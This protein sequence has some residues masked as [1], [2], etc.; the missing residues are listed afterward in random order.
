MHNQSIERDGVPP[1]LIS[2]VNCIKKMKI[3]NSIILILSVT[4][5]SA[6]YTINPDGT[7]NIPQKSLGDI[8]DEWVGFSEFYVYS[9]D[10]KIRDNG[11]GIM[12]IKLLGETEKK[13]VKVSI[14]NNIVKIQPKNP[15]DTWLITGEL[16]PTLMVI[17][18]KADQ[19]KH[20]PKLQLIRKTELLKRVNCKQNS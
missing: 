11:T 17:S 16:E 2:T 1:P 6:C 15:E 8:A 14:E 18:I 5:L 7:V 13:D 19:T 9:I 20:L 3:L 4:F 10:L 12:T